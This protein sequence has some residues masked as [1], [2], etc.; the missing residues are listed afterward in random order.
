MLIENIYDGW[1]K[2][3]SGFLIL[4]NVVSSIIFKFMVQK[5]WIENH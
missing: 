5:E 1:S 2:K 4:A 3:L